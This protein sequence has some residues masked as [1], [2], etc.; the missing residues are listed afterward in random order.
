MLAEAE[1][2]DVMK[3]VFRPEPVVP[4]AA[5]MDHHQVQQLDQVDQPTPV[6]EEA[7]VHLSLL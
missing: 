5:V 4:V 2:V 7:E 1:V 6:V 3:A